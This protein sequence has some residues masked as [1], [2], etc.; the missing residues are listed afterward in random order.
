MESSKLLV[1]IKDCLRWTVFYPCTFYGTKVV[2][3]KFNCSGR[4]CL[5]FSWT[6]S[7][8]SL[9]RSRTFLDTWV[10]YLLL[11]LIASRGLA[12]LLL[13]GSALWGSLSTSKIIVM[14]VHAGHL[15]LSSLGTL[16]SFKQN[17]DTM[18]WKFN[19]RN[20]LHSGSF[21]VFVVFEEFGLV[22]SL[23]PESSHIKII[24][25][26]DSCFLLFNLWAQLY[27]VVSRSSFRMCKSRL[28]P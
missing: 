14:T 2:L 21:L 10:W 25:S 16:L 5:S 17:F 24:Q 19:H 11:R 1:G 28:I 6:S 7:M 23:N 12:S 3:V 26:L 9:L 22:H 18:V 13:I 15:F 20:L 4:I 8:G 27:P